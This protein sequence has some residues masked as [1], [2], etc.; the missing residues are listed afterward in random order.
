M[1]QDHG[2]LLRVPEASIRLGLREATLRRMILERRIA[3]IRIGRAVRIPENAV[4]AL[5]AAGYSPAVS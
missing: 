4:D 5:I 2:R 1:S 3:T